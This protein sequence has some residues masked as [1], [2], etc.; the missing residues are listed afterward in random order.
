MII[1]LTGTPGCGKT[2]ASEEL[3]KKG[4]KV[5]S[6]HGFLDEKGLLNDFDV[7]C[8]SFQVDLDAAAEAFEQFLEEEGDLV[9]EGHLSHLL[10]CDKIV[11]LR[12]RPS[13]IKER[14]EGRGY[15][16]DKV[17]EN[18]EAEA[19]DVILVESL[20]SGRDTLELDG[21][22][23][24]AEEVAKALLEILGGESEKYLP[25]NIDWSEELLKWC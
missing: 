15:H 14:L 3:R 10:P 19:L 21:T 1:A 17:M 25:G 4:G 18:V 9:V 24:S 16:H 11:V 8:D 5:V 2:S 23:M 6:L 7:T 12:C 13:V 22:N 20:D